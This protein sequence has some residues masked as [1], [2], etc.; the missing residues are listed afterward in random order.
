MLFL[1]KDNYYY[2]KIKLILVNGKVLNNFL[3]AKNKNSTKKTFA[4]LKN[5]SIKVV[6]AKQNSKNICRH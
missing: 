1:N 4:K 2:S 6:L 3:V 5:N